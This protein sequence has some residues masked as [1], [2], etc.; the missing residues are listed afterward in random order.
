MTEYTPLT[1]LKGIGP[2]LADKLFTSGAEV[3]FGFEVLRALL[4]CASDA[5]M[6]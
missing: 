5:L 1:V 6:G 3:S 4:L 2:A